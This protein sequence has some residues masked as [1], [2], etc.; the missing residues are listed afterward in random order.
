MTAA[1]STRA[2]VDLNADVAEGLD[3]VDREL[4]EVVTSAN[5]ACGFHAGGE[6]EARAACELAAARGVAVGAHVGYRDR[7]GF[8][9]RELGVPAATV[10]AEALEQ[11]A[12]LSAWAGDVGTR[13][14][15]VKPHGAL[16]H[17]ATVDAECAGA[18]VRAAAAAGGL[19]I[20][21]FPGSQL[22]ARAR[23]AG[24]AAFDEAFGDRGYAADGSLV[25]RGS[26]GAV[27]DEDAAVSQAVR[28]AEAGEAR[29]I[30]LHGDSPGAAAIARRVRAGLEAAGFE[31]RAFA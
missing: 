30:C 7:D 27:L 22:V 16:Y 1:S 19:A 2:A 29:S 15:Y 8:G 6:A 21:A 4:L 9:R 14:A 20:L 10:E 26:P 17:R 31:L 5:V 13:V 12:A 11:I 24:L 3:D 25:P 18:I 28:L 23:E